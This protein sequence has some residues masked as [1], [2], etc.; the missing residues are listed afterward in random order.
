M[1]KPFASTALP[2]LVRVLFAVLV[3]TTQAACAAAALEMPHATEAEKIK[4]WVASPE[5]NLNRYG[6]A[7]DTMYTGGTPLFDE[8]TAGSMPGSSTVSACFHFSACVLLLSFNP[9]PYALHPNCRSPT[10]RSD[11]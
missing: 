3:A 4:A 9:N 8:S 7:A 5:L 2:S 11:P 6:D 10:P 1:T